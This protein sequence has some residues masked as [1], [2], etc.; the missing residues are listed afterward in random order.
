[1]YLINFSEKINFQ[2]IA[3]CYFKTENCSMKQLI[4]IKICIIFPHWRLIYST[5]NASIF[6]WCISKVKSLAS[7]PQEKN[8]FS[9]HNSGGAAL[10]YNIYTANILSKER[11]TTQPKFSLAVK[12]AEKMDQKVA[13]ERAVHCL[14]WSWKLTSRGQCR[15]LE[16]GCC[17]H[18]EKVSFL[19][20]FYELSLKLLWFNKRTTGYAI[21]T[22]ICQGNLIFNSTFCVRIP[23]WRLHMK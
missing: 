17:F 11:E 7:K 14:R 2:A 12:A 6:L 16:A 8:S 3:S 19:R 1:M 20:Y 22:T 9:E 4:F 18:Q 13:A 23:T 21:L 5:F 15:K 10:S